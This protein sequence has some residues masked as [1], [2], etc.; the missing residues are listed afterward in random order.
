MSCA[1]ARSEPTRSANILL[2]TARPLRGRQDLDPQRAAP[3][4]PHL[5]KRL[6]HPESHLATGVGTL[7][8]VVDREAT[9][10]IVLEHFGGLGTQEVAVDRDSALL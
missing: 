9:A 3:M 7:A 10:G 1:T 8:A 4:D 6:C 5:P 2:A